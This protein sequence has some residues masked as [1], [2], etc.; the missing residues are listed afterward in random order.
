MTKEEKI[1]EAYGEYWDEVKEFVCEY[2]WTQKKSLIGN[3]SNETFDSRKV[4]GFND[5]YKYRP[6]S[7]K[8]IENNNGWIKIES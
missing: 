8:G 4:I 6:K 3:F 5:T 7:L 1:Q 2:G